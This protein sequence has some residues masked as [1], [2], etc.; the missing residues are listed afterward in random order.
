MC[1]LFIPP[2]NGTYT[3]AVARPWMILKFKRVREYCIYGRLILLTADWLAIILQH[4][5]NGLVNLYIVLFVGFLMI[6]SPIL[7]AG[8]RGLQQL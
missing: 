6:G 5:K 7:V 8:T 4:I 3:T 2:N 1:V